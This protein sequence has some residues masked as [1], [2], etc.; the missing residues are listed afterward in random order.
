V[1]TNALEIN[2]L[3][4]DVYAGDVLRREYRYQMDVHADYA[5]RIAELRSELEGVE[6]KQKTAA[7]RATSIM[8]TL[9]RYGGMIP[10]GD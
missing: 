5:K 1:A 7:E 3:N 4:P 8:E 9:N 10:N 6:A 2:E